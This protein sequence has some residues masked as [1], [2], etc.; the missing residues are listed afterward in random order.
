[1]VPDA[2][3][4]QEAQEQVAGSLRLLAEGEITDHFVAETEPCV[5]E[6]PFPLAADDQEVVEDR[7]AMK[8]MPSPLHSYPQPEIP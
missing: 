4:A 1:M 7:R 6:G 8:L 5:T 3:G 2:Q